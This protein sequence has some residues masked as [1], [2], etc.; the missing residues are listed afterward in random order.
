M[1]SVRPSRLGQVASPRRL[2]PCK[3]GQL[4][5]PVARTPLGPTRQNYLTVLQ[6]EGRGQASLYPLIGQVRRNHVHV[7]SGQAC[8]AVSHL[9][10]LR[11]D[12]QSWNELAG[13]HVS[14]CCPP[15]TC[16]NC[17]ALCTVSKPRNRRFHAARAPALRI[18]T[19]I[20]QPRWL[21]TR[22]ACFRCLMT[23]GI[24]L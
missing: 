22:M 19:M 17:S 2:P 16:T 12:R 18:S 9:A 21:L 7:S 6:L 15:H 13:V 5:P 8:R 14:D 4:P 11:S 23:V 1:L 3:F 20:G 10:D 24:R